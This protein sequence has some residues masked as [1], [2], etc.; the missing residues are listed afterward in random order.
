M[1]SID[2][3]IVE[4]RFNNRDFERGISETL[5]SLDEL[6]K[7][8]NLQD[9]VSSLRGL[10]EEGNRFSLKGIADG[11]DTISNRFSALGAIGFTVIQDLTRSAL[12]FAKRIGG[13]I[14]TPLMEGGNRRAMNLEQAKFMFA[15][16]GMDVEATMESANQAV[17]GT[18][19]GLDEAA[20]AASQFGAT[21]MRAGDE[22]TTALRGISG[23]AAMTG[24]SYEDIS[25]IFTTV[26]GNGRM[27]GT[28]LLRL[29]G[30]GINAAATLA[31]HFG[32]TEQK[33]REMT[34][35]GKISFEM[36][37]QAMDAAFGEHSTR[38]NETYTGSLANMK[39][40][41]GRIGAEI[42]VPRLE[43]MRDVFNSLTPVINNIREALLPTIETFNKFAREGADKFIEYLDGIGEIDLSLLQVIFPR[44]IRTAQAGLAAF[45]AL[46]APIK[47]A[48]LQIFPPA[49]GATIVEFVTKIQQF[50][51]SLKMGEETADKVRRA[52][53]GLF[54]IFGIGWE[55][56]KT[57]ISMLGRLF[58]VATE[59]SGSFLDAAASLGDFLVS[60]HESVKAGTFLEDTFAKVEKAL[61][62]PINAIRWLG[63]EILEFFGIVD[64]EVTGVN[65]LAEFGKTLARVWERV[66]EVF[67]SVYRFFEPLI[68]G[69]KNLVF[70]VG[71]IIKGAIEEGDWGD[72]AGAASVAAIGGIAFAIG[73]AVRRIGWAFA[74]LV[75]DFKG[76][77]GI[78]NLVHSVRVVFGRLTGTLKTMQNELR[79][80]T[81]VSI[82]IAI[83][84]LA[85]SVAVLST[86]D[87]DKLTYAT[88]AMAS[89][90]AMLGFSLAGFQK[91]MGK[92]F[93]NIISTTTGLV[94]LS[95]AV[96][97]LS[98]ALKSMSGL[99]WDEMLI[100][101]GGVIGLLGG[102]VATVALLKKEA[103]SLIA[104]GVG[105][106][107]LA[108][109]IKILA[110]AVSDLGEMNWDEM[111]IGL[112]GV[113]ALI[114]GVVAASN[115]MGNPVKLIGTAIAMVILGG[116]MKIIAN[117]IKDF[118]GIDGVAEGLLAMGGAL[119][120]IAIGMSLMPKGMILQAAALIIISQ[121][122]T[123]ISDVLRE[124]ASM[125]WEEIGKASTMLL[126]ALGLIAA[127][128][129]VMAGALPG[130]AALI[131]VAGA[132][133]IMMPALTEMS[134][135]SW[136]GIGK[137]STML[138][139]ALG[140]IAAGMYVMVGALP[141][142]LA[143][144]VVAAGLNVLI[145]PLQAMAK[146]SWGEIGTGLAVLAGTLAIIA[147]A[148]M[149]LVP[150]LPGL[151]GLGAAIA[152]IGAGTLAA[153]VG[154]TAF[155]VG[156][157]LLVTAALLGGD[158]LTELAETVAG[159]IPTMAKGLAEGLLEF[160]K[161]LADGAPEFFEAMKTLLG[162]LLTAIDEMTPQIK[163]TLSGLITLLVD[164]IREKVPEFSDAGL[165][166]LKGVLAGIEEDIEEI[167]AT[168]LRIV[169][170]FIDGVAEGLPDIIDSGWNLIIT[171][172]DSM[173]ES[174]E[175]NLDDL[176]AAGQRLGW[177]IL[178]G[179]SGG[180]VSSKRINDITSKAKS[181]GEKAVNAVKNVL[182]IK[183][184][185]RVFREIGGQTTE[186]LSLGLMDMADNVERSSE[187]V[188]SSAMEALRKA[189][190]GAS[191]ILDSDMEMA[192]TIRPVL[193]LSEVRKGS[194]E[195]G[196]IF[197]SNNITPIVSFEKANVISA[198]TKAAQLRRAEVAEDA[199]S[200]RDSNGESYIFN[201]YNTSPKALS[202]G[203]IYRQTNN[204]LSIAKGGPRK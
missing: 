120:S 33:V 11:V 32:I 29:S 121:A 173:A 190:S 165:D 58:G 95:V 200:T 102:L 101:L 100:G 163:E 25:S 18:A 39:T 24:S 62:Y 65:K 74:G 67:K 84:I 143:L 203:E 49:S 92:G 51:E 28:E 117:A 79:A 196:D 43:Y 160:V 144:V 69:I 142:A 99:D 129:Y 114:G 150:A 125:S 112:G 21:G 192:P 38:A 8:L 64:D 115:F 45:L 12:N 169:S 146:M 71:N 94:L 85:A 76:N 130:A 80:K 77:L 19:F 186:G 54:A 35:E 194:G 73:N 126:A 177:A 155:A 53:A 108:A 3:R 83:G 9:G 137:A 89:M 50:V 14:I 91:V 27:M 156:L 26:A 158:A 37:Y 181:I 105:T 87:P 157:G 162:E 75:R 140:L 68:N 48:F 66:V 55:I 134:E 5:R 183:S 72:V 145:P 13:A 132:L 31:E 172:I 113:L 88:V 20:K 193:D 41:L 106:I 151:L 153:G 7:G 30:R 15:G 17:L 42:H 188:G 201:Q 167:T 154:I 46:I 82:A 96:L 161:T 107:T 110:S 204:Q 133:R 98:S 195:I 6:K 10:Q 170:N 59:G 135:M 109:G 152:L 179:M 70:E 139:A 123:F 171:F 131:V 90:F 104:F 178:E 136:E 202:S 147:G 148:G 57:G 189:V 118:V 198:E 60:V 184:P 36:F 78:T 141:G 175:D 166:I 52:F 122:L 93:A 174:I 119:V 34:S 61:L 4:M 63:R 149:L 176:K 182:R 40:A 81:L 168:A 199:P 159:V 22:M 103:P 44:V 187:R 23:V 138:L 16:L 2:H 111:L 124:M 56:V 86:I 164:L 1:S 127:G 185:S 191:T 197:K 116:A 128:M 97:I 180:L 47:D